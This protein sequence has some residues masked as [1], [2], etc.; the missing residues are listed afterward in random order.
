MT[1]ARGKRL[2]TLLTYAQ[3]VLVSLVI[4][5][6][7]AWMLAASFKTSAEVTAYPPR[8][9]FRPTLANYTR[10]FATTPF[11]E[12]TRNSLIVAGVST[13]LGLLLAVPAA[14]AVSWYR[15]TWP[16]TLTLAARMAPGTLFLLPWYIMFSN[17][18]LIGSHWTLILTH[19]VITMPLVLWVMM[20]FFDAIPREVLESALI[21]G[22]SAS[23]ALLR[24]AIPLVRPGIVVSTILAFVFAWNYFLFALVLSGFSSKTLPVAAFNF[25]G[26]GAT[27]WGGLMAAAVLIALPPLILAFFVQRWLVHGLTF[28]AVK[29]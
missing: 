16:A 5:V 18:G 24:V 23:A 1:S 11:L 8:L 19:T 14:Y 6:P 13:A 21:D 9:L 7:V 2:S 4:V 12:Y 27:N 26:E 10:L 20:S 22:C 29:G 3:F 15:I 28:G 17:L 25:I